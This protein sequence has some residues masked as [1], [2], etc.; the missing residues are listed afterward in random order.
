MQRLV[1]EHVSGRRDH[2][3][4]LWRLIALNL[5]I[6]ALRTNALSQAATPGALVIEHAGLAR[7]V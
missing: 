3:A 1:R 4:M 7:A 6:A 5:W 2:S